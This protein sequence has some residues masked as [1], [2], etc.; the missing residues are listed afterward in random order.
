MTHKSC[1]LRPGI[2]AQVFNLN[3]WEAEA[4]RTL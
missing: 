4:D 1:P 3:T 2:M